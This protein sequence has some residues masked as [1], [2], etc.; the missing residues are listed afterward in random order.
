MAGKKGN[1]SSIWNFIDNFEG[2][3]IIWMI[4]LIL[5]MFS[6]L[7]VSSSTPLLAIMQNST[8]AEIIKDQL[9]IAGVGLI[10]IILVYNIKQIWI[11]R[12][13]SQ[14]GFLV[15]FVLLMCL[16]VGI[17]LP[18]MKAVT[19]NGAVRALQIGGFQLH[20]FEFVKIMMVMYLAWAV[21]SYENDKFLLANVLGKTDTFKFLNKDIWKK[22]IYIYAPILIVCVLVMNGS[23]SSMLFIGLIMGVTIIIGGIKVKELIPVGVV[24][25]ILIAGAV[26]IAEVSEGK[27]FGRIYTAVGRITRF[28]EDPE[29]K[30]LSMEKGTKEFY[31]ELDKV[32]QPI[33]AKVAVSEGGLWGKG[34][35]RST[36]RYIV[37]VMFEDYMF[38]F[39]IEEYGILGAI[40]IMI[41][42]CS[43]LARGSLV[44]RNCN[45][46]YAK[47]AVAGL[48]ILISGQAFMHM[49][50][51]VDLGPM[52][53][54]TLPMISHGKSA[55]LAFSIAFGIILAISRMAK[56]NI[57]KEIKNVKPLV[58]PNVE[59]DPIQ[60]SISEVES[61]DEL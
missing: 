24:A 48:V 25:A 49:L 32:R 45:N 43:L 31:D 12:E 21:S 54:Q 41:L 59:P 20:V 28:S 27:Y 26:G 33:S 58:E 5:I 19:I 18:F 11:F 60:E 6:I 53:G 2:D 46:V 29:E 4:V 10:A 7:A 57:D 14:L 51:N 1:K 42:Y 15:S 50:I 61:L 47:T 36:Q 44:V 9:I 17:D 16:F 8:R 55:F 56:S 40:I 22:I 35:G 3:K 23:M 34:P 13:F 38:S 30:L 37:P 39:I 52:T